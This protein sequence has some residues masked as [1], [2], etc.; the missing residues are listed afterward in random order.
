MIRRGVTIA[1]TILMLFAAACATDSSNDGSER[2]ISVTLVTNEPSEPTPSEDPSTTAAAF[3]RSWIRHDLPQDKWWAQLLPLC[4]HQYAPL[5]R[6]QQVVDVPAQRVTGPPKAVETQNDGSTT[7]ALET[8]AG[9]LHVTL[10]PQDGRWKVLTSAFYAPG[11]TPE[12][13]VVAPTE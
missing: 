1:M 7:Y 10:I 2:G 13:P 9:S 5:L 6:T 4:T 12:Q 3:A 11:T 8:D